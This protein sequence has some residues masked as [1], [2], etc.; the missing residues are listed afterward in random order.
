[1][2][3]IDDQ[4]Q[5]IIKFNIDAMT[6][7]NIDELLGICKGITFDGIINEL[8]A[9]YLLKWIDDHREYVN[10]YP[11]NV[12]YNR[13]KEML[14]DDILDDQEAAELI[15]I[16]KNLNGDKNKHQNTIQGSTTL[17]LNDP[18][19][20]IIIPDNS[21]VFTGIFTIG[22][23]KQCEEIICD[24]GGIMHKSM[25]NDTNYLVIGGIGSEQWAHSSFGRK[26]EKAIFLRD[27]KQTGLSIVSEQHWIKFL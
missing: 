2:Q 18:L 19:P 23:R 22:A 8:E 27:Q 17:P 14:Q 11:F 7:R 9:K 24:L 16:I 25:K 21:F 13:L 20:D 15:E 12:L 5:P 10:I 1:M 6:D 3:Y 4:G 26:I